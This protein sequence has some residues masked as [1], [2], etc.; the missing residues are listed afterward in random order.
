MTP[1]CN[2]ENLWDTMKAKSGGPRYI[3]PWL[4]QMSGEQIPEIVFPGWSRAGS[5]TKKGIPLKIIAQTGALPLITY[6]YARFSPEVARRQTW[7]RGA[8]WEKHGIGSK[9]GQQSVK[10]RRCADRKHLR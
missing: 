9:Q 6:G 3:R 1:F 5:D 4:F 10:L 2:L 7:L 8:L